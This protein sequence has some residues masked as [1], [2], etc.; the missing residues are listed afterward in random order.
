[1]FGAANQ[2][3]DSLALLLI[4]LWLMSKVKNYQWTLW[5]FAFMFVTTI[6][7]LAFK[8]YEAFFINLPKTAD[9][10]TYK[11]ANVG[12]YTTAQVIIGII[13][14][15]LIGTAFILAWDGLAAIRR[16]RT[17]AGAKAKA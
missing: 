1:M 2:L 13:A 14:L 15:I 10:A 3:M 4:T 12:E 9:P 16:Y 17:Q 8:A 11:I 7:A 5:P 6:G